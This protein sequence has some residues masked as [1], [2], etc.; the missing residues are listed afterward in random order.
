MLIETSI[1]GLLGRFPMTIAVIIILT[2]ASLL[3]SYISF[4]KRI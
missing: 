1:T 4:T 2:K 3:S